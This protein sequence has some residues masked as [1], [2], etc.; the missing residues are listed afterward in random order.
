[1]SFETY[2]RS[3]IKYIS[4]HQ[5]PLEEKELCMFESTHPYKMNA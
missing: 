2:G 1:M 4:E 3:E 5:I